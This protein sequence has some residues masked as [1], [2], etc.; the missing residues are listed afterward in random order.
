L[1][2]RSAWSLVAVFRDTFQA[3]GFVSGGGQD[4]LGVPSPGAVALAGVAGLA[5]TRRRR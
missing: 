4:D 5:A 1:G 2:S 3:L